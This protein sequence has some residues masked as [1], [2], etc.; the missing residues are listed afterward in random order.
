MF[1]DFSFSNSGF[2][3]IDPRTKMILFA[4]CSFATLMEPRILFQGIIFIFAYLLL[5]NGKQYRSA[6]KMLLIYII[7]LGINY[8]LETT[9][10]NNAIV[11]LLM[12]LMI[13]RMFVPIIM[14]FM[15]MIRTTKVSEFM[16]AFDKMHVPQ[17][18][19]IPFSVMFRFFPTIGEEFTNIQNA[20]KLRGFALNWKNI[21]TKPALVYECTIVPLLSDSVIIADE[22]S[23]ASLCRGLGGTEK[24]TSMVDVKM[25]ITDYLLI[26]FAIWLNINANMFL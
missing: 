19:T 2:V 9:H 24:R 3:K 11:V 4:L 6:Q 10:L 23:A 15:Y 26:A 18:I 8:A 13:F 21:F 12:G 20:M 1:N 14:I 17:Q 22:I 25:R 5:I 7:L 16:V